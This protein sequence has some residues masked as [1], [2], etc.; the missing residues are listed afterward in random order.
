MNNACINNITMFFTILL[1][2]VSNERVHHGWAQKKISNVGTP[3]WPEKAVLGAFVV[4]RIEKEYPNFFVSKEQIL[5]P[6]PPFS[7]GMG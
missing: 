3:R 4:N 5:P 2:Q 7:E 6:S 1:Y